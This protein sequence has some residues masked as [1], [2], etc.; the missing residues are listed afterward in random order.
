MA[1]ID[2]NN[3]FVGSVFTVVLLLVKILAKRYRENKLSQ[4][5][6]DLPE[7]LGPYGV[8]C[9]YLSYLGEYIYLYVGLH[10][11]KKV[12]QRSVGPTCLVSLC[13]ERR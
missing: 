12:G 2:N 9:V 11:R 10:I 1:G 4:G 13:V 7:I 8:L 5:G 3:V 6:S